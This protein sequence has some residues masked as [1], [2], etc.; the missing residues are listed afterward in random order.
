MEIVFHAT[1]VSH[2]LLPPFIPS[3][4]RVGILGVYLR[5][6]LNFLKQVEPVVANCNQRLYLL[7]QLKNKALAYLHISL[8]FIATGQCTELA[9][10]GDIKLLNRSS[11]VL[12]GSF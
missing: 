6:N 12:C 1:N 10:P 2:D 9:G 11:P 3:V 4:S 8:S 5:Y 7:T